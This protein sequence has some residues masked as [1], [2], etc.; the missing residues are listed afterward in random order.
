MAGASSISF[1]VCLM[2]GEIDSII[3]G[4]QINE[5][6]LSAVGIVVSIST[7]MYFI[8]TTISGGAPVLFTKKMGEHK[9]DEAYKVIGTSVIYSIILGI[10]MALLL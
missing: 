6:A 5:Q 3:A 4:N 8:S 1:F 7:L 9:E 2:S 10:V